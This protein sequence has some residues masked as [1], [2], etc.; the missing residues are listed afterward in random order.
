MAMDEVKIQNH[1][2]YADIG[3]ELIEICAL[4]YSSSTLNCKIRRALEKAG[5][6]GK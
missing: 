2:G 6:T 5:A 1:L 4:L 3:H